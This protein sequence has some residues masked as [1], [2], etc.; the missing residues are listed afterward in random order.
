M[1]HRDMSWWLDWSALPERRLWACLRALD[2]GNAEVLD[3]DGG[4]HAFPTEVAARSWLLEDEYSS[5]ATLIA[6]G[7]IPADIEPPWLDPRSTNWHHDE[8]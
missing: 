5:L 2:N 4:R 8:H 3:C 6:D 1:A 7:E